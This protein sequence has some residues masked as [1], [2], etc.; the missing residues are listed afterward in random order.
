MSSIKRQ[1]TTSQGRPAYDFQE[2]RSTYDDQLAIL[3][4]RLLQY[5]INTIPSTALSIPPQSSP[6]LTALQNTVTAKTTHSSPKKGMSEQPTMS[7]ATREILGKVRKM[8][9]PMLEKFHKGIAHHSQYTLPRPELNINAKQDKWAVLELS[10][11][12]RTTPG[13]HTSQRWLPHGWVVIWYCQSSLSVLHFP[14]RFGGFFTLL[15]QPSLTPTQSH[16]ICE[17]QAATVI[18]TYSPN[19]MVHPLMR[20]SSHASTSDTSSSL[21]DS[22]VAMLPRLHVLVVGPGLGRDPLMQDTCAHVLSAARKQSIPFVLDA[23]GLL[24]AQQH[25]ELVQG[26]EECILTPNVVEFARLAKSKGLDEQ[27]IDEMGKEGKEGEGAEKLSRAFGGVT[28]VRKGRED[29]I[30]NGETTVRCDVVGGRKRSGGQGDT[31]TGALATFL[32]WRKAYL[33]GMWEHDGSLESKE[34]L[35]LVAFGG[36]ALTRVS[37]V[38]CF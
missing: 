23:D 4:G 18:K 21:A 32:G 25:P 27:E 7:P 6:N 36:S 10:V 11:G 2:Q 13:H 38:F 5:S 31:L 29:W 33:E 24:L 34:L 22:I 14:R 37:G 35:V 20:K 15:N 28:V 8:I 30:S 19:L 26:Y 17:P 16:V 3:S 12:A 9:P 1:S